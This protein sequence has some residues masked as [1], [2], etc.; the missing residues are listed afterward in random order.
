MN[1]IATTGITWDDT[2]TESRIEVGGIVPEVLTKMAP[3][4]IEQGYVIGGWDATAIPVVT[5]PPTDAAEPVEQT[6]V[7]VTEEPATGERGNG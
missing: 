5:I 6:D 1:W 3:W 2:G 7:P 4:L